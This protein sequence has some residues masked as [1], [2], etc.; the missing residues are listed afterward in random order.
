[1]RT[2]SPTTKWL[3]EAKTIEELKALYRKLAFAH[4]PDLGGKTATMQEINAEYEFR[5]KQF[6]T[7]KSRNSYSSWS[8]HSNSNNHNSSYNNNWQ[9]SN[10][11]NNNYYSYQNY[12]SYNSPPPPPPPNTENPDPAEAREAFEKTTA[13]AS[14]A[15]PW[16]HVA[17]L[18]NGEVVAYGRTYPH[19]DFLRDTGFWWDPERRVWHFVRKPF[20]PYEQW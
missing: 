11:S 18:E 15:N 10:S 8:S 13:Y 9:N 20:S 2:Y 1:M 3:I 14:K 4:H 16:F 5:L 7:G 19:R 12:R 6:E 17:T